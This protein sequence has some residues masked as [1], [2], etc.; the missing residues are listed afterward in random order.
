MAVAE[1]LLQPFGHSQNFLSSIFWI[2]CKSLVFFL[3]FDLRWGCAQYLHTSA[4]IQTTDRSWRGDVPLVPDR[5]PQCCCWSRGWPRLP[6]S[7]SSLCLHCFMPKAPD[8]VCT[9]VYCIYPVREPRVTWVHTNTSPCCL[10]KRTCGCSLSFVSRTVTYQMRV[11][12]SWYLHLISLWKPD[13]HIHSV[14]AF[15]SS[16]WVTAN[17]PRYI[18]L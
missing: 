5:V 11:Q 8:G 3:A 16:F 14:A 2:V 13:L 12:L 9:V 15:W 7:F 6:C 17:T 18:I 4:L 1:E 10:I